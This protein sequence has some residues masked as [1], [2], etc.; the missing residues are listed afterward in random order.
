MNRQVLHLRGLRAH[1]Q[2]LKLKSHTL[3][4]GCTKKN[5]RQFKKCAKV[6]SILKDECARKTQKTEVVLIEPF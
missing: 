2:K 6:P 5:K 4:S 3:P 1:A